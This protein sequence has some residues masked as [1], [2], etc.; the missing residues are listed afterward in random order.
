MLFRTLMS[1]I[2]KPLMRPIIRIERSYNLQNSTLINNCSSKQAR[3]QAN[4]KN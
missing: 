3:F 1:E 2:K 4:K